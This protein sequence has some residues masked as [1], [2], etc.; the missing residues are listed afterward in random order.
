MFF[1]GCATH[2][3]KINHIIPISQRRAPH[4]ETVD[5]ALQYYFTDEAYDA[6]KGIPSID[7]ITFGGSYV[8]G[9]NVWT[10]LL[11]VVTRLGLGRKVVINM[12][13]LK[14]NGVYLLA[15]EYFHHIDDMTRDGDIDLVSVEEFK[16][17][18][19]RFK[20]EYPSR[21]AYVN[22]FADR[23][24]TDLF[25]VGEYSEQMAYTL[26]HTLKYGGPQYMKYVYRKVIRNWK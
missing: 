17:A 1:T 3:T 15:H 6:V 5:S 26:N 8:A 4:H 18:W 21:A 14:N 22:K 16:P 11:A 2:I 24:L 19:A 23:I 7:G 10:S 9:V 12:K 25:G 20:K 13:G